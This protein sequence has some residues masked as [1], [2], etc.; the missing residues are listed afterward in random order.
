VL[1]TARKVDTAFNPGTQSTFFKTPPRLP[2]SNQTLLQKN[3]SMMLS[4]LGVY[5]EE[6]ETNKQTYAEDEQDD[7]D[8]TTDRV[9]SADDD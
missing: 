6:I 9:N 7:L 8:A 5:K 1:D 4:L 3:S 2:K